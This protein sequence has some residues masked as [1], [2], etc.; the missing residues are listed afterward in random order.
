MRRSAW[1]ALA[2]FLAVRPASAGSFRIGATFEWHRSYRGRTVAAFLVLEL[3]LDRL[4]APRVAPVP[5]TLAEGPAP[6]ADEVSETPAPTRVAPAREATKPAPRGEP[7]PRFE[8]ASARRL[9][10]AALRAQ[11]L[12]A[13]SQ[14]LDG[15]AS[16]ARASAILPELTLRAV[17]SNDE[18]LRLAPS[19]SYENG[20]TQT[21]GAGLL[22]EAR[23]LWRLDRVV[24]ADEEIP[25]ERLRVERARLA[26]QVTSQVLKGLFRVL[27]ARSRLA[28]LLLTVEE[29]SELELELLE[30]VSLLDVLTDGEFGREEQRRAL[31]AGNF[32]EKR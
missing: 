11:G 17:R 30:A 23:A 27:R 24:F 4:A 14:R 7:G 21:G 6:G 25:V 1:L 22:L 9:V 8:P 10:V 29:R 2:L 12:L 31:Q 15:L 13:S 16:R 18:S 28:E 3:P 20:Y 19:A 26:E 32:T 5:H